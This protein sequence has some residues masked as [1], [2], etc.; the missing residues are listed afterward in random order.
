[1]SEGDLF[2]SEDLLGRVCR[3]SGGHLRNLFILMRGCVSRSETLPISEQAVHRAI[4]EEAVNLVRPLFA[5]HRKI[6]DKVYQTKEP[7]EDDPALWFELLRN[8]YIYAYEDEQGSWYDVNPLYH[9]LPA[10]KGAG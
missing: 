9:V 3:L 8:H 2:G 5:K 7:V 10:P 4:R 1:V 6:L